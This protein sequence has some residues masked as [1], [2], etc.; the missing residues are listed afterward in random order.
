MSG[1]PGEASEHADVVVVGA[2]LSGVGAAHRL[3]TAHPGRTLVVLEARE[4][5]GGTWDLFRYP[6]VRSDSDMHTLGYAFR[7]WPG[8]RALADGP[9]ILA[10]VEDTAAELGVAGL[11]R[12]S[13][14]VVAAD[15]DTAGALW[16]LTVRDP[17]DGRE[18]TMTCGFLYSCAGYYDYARPH[19]PDIPGLADFAGPLVHPQAWP[20]DLDVRDRRVVVVGSGATAVTLVPAL[21]GPE[22]GAAH[23]TMLQ[24]SPTWVAAVPGTDRT[25]RRLGRV[26][27]AAL[28]HRLVRTRNVLRQVGTYGLTRRFPGAARRLLTGAA[29][30]HLGGDRTT[31]AEHFTPTYDP[32]DQR[33]CAAPDGDLFA[34]VR[35]GRAEVV[36]DRVARVVPDG[37]ELASGRTLPADVLVTATGLRLLAVGGTTLRVDGVEVDLAEQV[38]WHGAMVTGLPNFAVCIGYT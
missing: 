24:S 28:A 13:Q 19:T 20:A 26:L 17:R 3:R 23:V 30:R 6:G 29:V 25:A 10:Y 18:R 2:G 21:L 35:S 22:Q 7:P 34:A 4:R 33:L 15:F 14:Q 11:V 8:E 12:Y 9:S 1:H 38:V 32:W 16:T 5:M 37:V 27:P 36:T 31:V